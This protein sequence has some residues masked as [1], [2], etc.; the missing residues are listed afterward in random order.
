MKNYTFPW[1]QKLLDL[2]LKVYLVGGCVRDQLLNKEPKDLDYLVIGATLDEIESLISE[3]GKVDQVGKSFGVI[4]LQANGEEFDIAIPRKDKKI[5]DGHK[6]FTVD[7]QNI[8]LEEDLFRRD[9]TINSIAMD[10]KTFE[11]ID[12]YN[13]ILDIQMEILRM[14]N[15]D[16]FADDALRILRCIQFASRFDF[17]IHK[18]TIKLIIENIHLLKDLSAERITLELDKIFEKGNIY[19]GFFLLQELNIIEILTGKNYFVVYEDIINKIK[20]RFDFYY[21]LFHN[22]NLEFFKNK[23]KLDNDVCI[24]IFAL[25][26][27]SEKELH[28]DNFENRFDLFK[29]TNKNCDILNT[30]LCNNFQDYIKEFNEGKYPKTRSELAINGNDLLAIGY[31]GSNIKLMLDKCIKLVLDNFPNN[32][33]LLIKEASIPGLTI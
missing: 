23:L 19:N 27:L 32:K 7:T 24:S 18:D 22:E 31:E 20:T 15:P 3:F 10:I 33:E 29:F 25:K 14:T 1:T 26:E 30:G 17:K 21:A 5:G 4:K 8:T 16:A 2:N 9:F 28:A 6:G 11:Y 13:G 12:P